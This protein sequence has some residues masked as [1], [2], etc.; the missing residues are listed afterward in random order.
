MKILI[1]I[2]VFL[3]ILGGGSSADTTDVNQLNKNKLI[4]AII[5]E[6]N[7]KYVF[8]DLAKKMAIIL[9]SKMEKG[10]YSTFSISQDLA[11]QIEKDLFLISKDKHLH[12]LFQK[13]KTQQK[14]RSSFLKNKGEPDDNFGFKKV[15]ILPGNIG[16]LKID[17]MALER[18]ATDIA[19]KC[20]KKISS[21]K[22]LIFD[23]RD[24]QGGASGMV[25]LLSSYL[26]DKPIHL[27]SM[28]NRLTNETK[29]IWTFSD[30][31]GQKLGE[32]IP[33]YILTS[34]KTFS[35]AEG[36]VYSLKHHQRVVV[37]GERTGGGA[38]PIIWTK[39]PY[40]F[41]LCIPFARIIHP[42]TKTDWEKNG[43]IPHHEVS[44]SVA[45]ETAIKLINK[46]LMGQA[47]S[48]KGTE[49]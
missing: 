30:F 17:R 37:V 29:D 23:L 38:H 7:N 39:L 24:N 13:S 46:N 3:I 34:S 10:E 33:V 31:P 36:F 48:D 14:P 45:L 15:E 8:P 44:A 22:A 28:F 9:K 47:R 32:D 16:Y 2:I 26:F 42:K 43:V 12:L 27:Y 40:N 11:S 18:K 4:V 20:V 49:H 19:A 41:M 35:A 1:F 5:M 6:L 25:I 21:A